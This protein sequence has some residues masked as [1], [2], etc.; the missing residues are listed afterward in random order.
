MAQKESHEIALAE[1]FAEIARSLLDEADVDAT[2]RRICPLAEETVPNCEAAGISI[3][4]GHSTPSNRRG[5]SGFP[6]MTPLGSPPYLAAARP[7]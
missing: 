4:T 2:L 7:G 5:V 6:N 3:R 1:T